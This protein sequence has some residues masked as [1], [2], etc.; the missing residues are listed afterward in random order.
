V[1]MVLDMAEFVY[2]SLLPIDSCVFLN[3]FFYDVLTLRWLS[4]SNEL[5]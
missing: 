1:T 5:L 3:G 4:T 2:V